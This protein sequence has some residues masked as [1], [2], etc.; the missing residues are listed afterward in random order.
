MQKSLSVLL[1][2]QSSKE[3][4]QMGIK[5]SGM[6]FEIISNQNEKTLDKSNSQIPQKKSS[7]SIISPR[8]TKTKMTRLKSARKLFLKA[9]IK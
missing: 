8:N 3:R 9:D 2:I 6:K 5:K 1:K 4:K 7:P